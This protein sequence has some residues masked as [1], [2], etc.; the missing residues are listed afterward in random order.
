MSKKIVI[1]GSE[2]I[3]TTIIFNKISQSHPI[4]TVII[5][6]KENFKLYFSRRIKK[7]GFFKVLGQFL[8]MLIVV[9]ILKI[10]SRKR[11]NDLN[12]KFDFNYDAI[13]QI[14]IKNVKSVNS[15]ETIEALQ[16]LEPDVILVAGTRIISN[17]VLSSVRSKFINIHAGITPLYRGVHGA[18]WALINNDIKNM[19]VTVHFVDKGIDTGAILHQE[20][21]SITT[22]DNFCTYPLI[23]LGVGV[24]NLNKILP[25]ILY[26]NF[27]LNDVNNDSKGNL[28][29]HP[30]LIQYLINRIIKGIK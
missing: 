13:P 30:T 15:V 4:D 27:S 10:T 29:Y 7:Q 22:Q 28:W 26:D 20:R 3:S 14:K 16:Q 12:I 21:I 9:P 25:D 23:Q 1:L 11:I 19:G 6:Q 24:S 5:E 17:K 18:Y 8:F 2:S